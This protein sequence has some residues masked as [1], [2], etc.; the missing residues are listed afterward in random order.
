[1]RRAAPFAGLSR[2]VLESV[3]DMLSGRYPSDEFA[4]LRPRIVWDRVTGTLSRAP[5]RPAPRGHLR[6]HHPRPRPVCR[7]PRLRRRSRPTGRRA[8]RGDG[9]RVAGRRHLHPRH[10]DLADRGH[11]PRPR[12]R[13][14][15]ARPAGQ[16]AVLEGRHDRSAVEL[17]AAVGAFVREVGGLGPSRS[18]RAGRRRRARRVGHRQPARLPRRAA[19]GHP[20]SCRPT[21][22]SSSSA[23]ATSSATGGS[24]CTPPTA[25][26]ARAVG[27]GRRGADA[28]ALRRRR[29]GH[30]RRRRHRAA[31]ARHGPAARRVGRRGRPAGSEGT[32]R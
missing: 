13:H 20:A 16:A 21:A 7:V 4:E 30:A 14:S 11:H 6:R 19:R 2:L 26:G 9:L 17:G 12:A 18:P 15:R 10:V 3:L 27:A 22:R 1:V 23:S 28:R 24:S 29:P 25:P 31:P 5:R 32:G 8:R